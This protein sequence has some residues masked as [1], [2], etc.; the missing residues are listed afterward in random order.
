MK[1]IAQVRLYPTKDQHATLKHTLEM[2]NAACNYI[3]A[4]AFEA[5]IFH[6]YGMQNLTYYDARAV[7]PLG[8]DGHP[9]SG[10]SGGRLRA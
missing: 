6:R 8:A 5:Q 10:E 4:R 2:A 3:S 9:L 1:L 7:R